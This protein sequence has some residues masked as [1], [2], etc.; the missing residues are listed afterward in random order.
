VKDLKKWPHT[1]IESTC[2][3]ITPAIIV[4]YSAATTSDIEWPD[5]K[6][7]MDYY[8]WYMLCTSKN[9]P[10]EMP[11]QK[12]K[13]TII[14]LC[15]SADHESFSV[16]S[17][18][19]WTARAWPTLSIFDVD[20]I[21]GWCSDNPDKL[22]EKEDPLVQLPTT[23]TIIVLVDFEMWWWLCGCERTCETSR[24]NEDGNEQYRWSSRARY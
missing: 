2:F 1:T 10:A 4:C 24:N 19:F 6:H 11:L 22:F 18:M 16:R 14:P 3:S 17:L 9:I 21:S 5:S 23:S 8:P 12:M 7:W 15:R 13:A 20:W